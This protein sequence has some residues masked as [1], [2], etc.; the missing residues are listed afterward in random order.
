MLFYVLYFL[1]RVFCGGGNNGSG[2]KKSDDFIEKKF[3]EILKL[4][5][6]F[7]SFI[8]FYYMVLFFFDIEF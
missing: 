3:D 1:C 2:K 7:F 6:K 8:M 5:V 4:D